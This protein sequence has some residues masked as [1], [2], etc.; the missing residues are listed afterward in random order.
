M[1]GVYL[2]SSGIIDCI[3]VVKY[4]E[5]LLSKSLVGVDSWEPLKRA[6]TG[7]VEYCLTRGRGD[8]EGIYLDRREVYRYSSAGT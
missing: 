7:Y 6:Y 4:N 5:I 3:S 2:S 1:G 8:L